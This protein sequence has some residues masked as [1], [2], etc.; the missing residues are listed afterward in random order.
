MILRRSH[1]L[2]I[3][4]QTLLLLV[5]SLVVSQLVSIAL[6]IT[7]QPPRPDFNRLSDVA[8]VLAGRSSDRE[9]RERALVVFVR[10][11]PPVADDDMISDP[12]FTA[13]LADRIGVPVDRVRLYFEPDQ[14]SGFPFERRR[15][16]GRVP[17]RRGEPIFFNTVVAGLHTGA[18][19]RVV[20]TPARP[21]LGPWQRRAILWFA[22]SALV[23]V[24]F[25]WLFARRL[26]R[27]IRR[28][29]DAADRLGADPFAP[30]VPTAEGPA[31]LRITAQALNRMQQRLAEY[32]SERTAMV[33]AIAHDLRTPLARIAFRIEGAPDEMREKV[34]ADIEQMRAMIAA[35][36][37][38]VRGTGDGSERRPVDLAAL[39]GAIAAQD[40][41]MGRNV[42]FAGGGP[43]SVMGD[44]VALARLFQNLIDNGL[45][46]GG[47]VHLRVGKEGG[48]ATVVVADEGPGLPEALLEKVF[49][50]FERGDPS[51][52]RTTGGVGLGLTIARKIAGEQGG[53][54][55]L[56]N[57]P[58][59]GLEAVCSF[60]G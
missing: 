39:L 56:R 40:R 15:H 21:A 50:P 37:G 57:R 3:F 13:R 44:A 6:L 24:P 48:R 52:N 41:E 2:P 12:R 10:S 31:E 22:V 1:G 9:G 30:A 29:A 47:A 33:G 32:V 58:E 27:P 55:I 14:R 59:G 20:E 17:M 43:V 5:A 35:T 49:E 26:A 34:Q 38:F 4:W 16:A 45:A 42:D 8:E 7:L 25:A 11:K 53:T 28:F 51:R 46:Y 18:G 23:L 54:L 36:I 60:P 19:W